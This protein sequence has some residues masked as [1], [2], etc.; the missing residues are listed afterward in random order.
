[1]KERGVGG[2]RERNRD[3]ISFQFKHLLLSIYS[4]RPN[5]NEPLN[6]AKSIFP[7]FPLTDTLPIH[8]SRPT[9]RPHPLPPI[10]HES[11]LLNSLSLYQPEQVASSWDSH[12]D[13]QHRE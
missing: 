4:P 6:H 2:R 10:H 11:L 1:M 3:T 5:L 13:S 8:P 7:S 12:G 9:L